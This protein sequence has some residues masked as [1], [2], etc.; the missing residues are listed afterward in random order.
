MMMLATALGITVG[1]AYTLSPLFVLAIC[2]FA[3]LLREAWRTADLSERR[4]LTALLM[5]AMAVRLAVIAVLFLST[6]HDRVPFGRLFGDEEYF[7]RRGIWL[8][9]VALGVPISIADVQYAFDDLIHTSFVWMLASLNVLFGPAQYGVRFVSAVVY[10]AGALALYRIVR[11]SFGKPAALTGFALLLFLPSLLVWSISVLKEPVF[12]AVM[13]TVV[14]LTVVAGRRGSWPLRLAAVAVVV[15]AALV[16]ETIREGGLVVAGAGTLVGII[17]AACLAR[18]RLL[19]ALAVVALAFM[20]V[21]LSSGVATDRLTAAG[22]A[23][24]RRHW[25]H[26]NAPGHSYTI[27]AAAFYREEPIAGSLTTA[28]ELRFVTG[29]LAAYL[30]LPLPWQMRS[31]SELAYLPEQVIW[32]GL[33]LLLPAGIVASLRRDPFLASILLGH[34][35]VS[36]ALVA[37]TSGNIGTLVRHRALAMPYVVW[38]SGLGLSVVLAWLV[39][40]LEAGTQYAAD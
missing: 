8:S 39:Q 28:D 12:F 27:L 1:V 35:A 16:A 24:A 5:S 6:D 9:N 4:W 18:P 17:M 33:A 13:T 21:V 34:L 32:Y 2:G 7:I 25:D 23:A 29:G 20:P 15:G 3:L 40:R 19:A 10:L 38:F 36:V 26:V 11:P 37:L 30:V 14:V 22:A 31:S